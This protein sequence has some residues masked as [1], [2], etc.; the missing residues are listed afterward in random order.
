MAYSLTQDEL[1]EKYLNPAQLLQLA[2]SNGLRVSFDAAFEEAGMQIAWKW[3]E[4]YVEGKHA[5]LQSTTT[6]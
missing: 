4:C 2:I 1:Q 6:M 3:P 5:A